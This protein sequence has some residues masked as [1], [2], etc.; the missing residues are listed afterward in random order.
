MPFTTFGYHAL[1]SFA[2]I[3]EK[4]YGKCPN[5]NSKLIKRN[6]KYGVFV[7]CSKYPRCKYTRDLK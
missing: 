1:K 7:G 3:L 4:S 6:G 2:F 5:C